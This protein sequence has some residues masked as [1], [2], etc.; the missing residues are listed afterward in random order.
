MKKV[1]VS[2]SGMAILLVVIAAGFL[3]ASPVLAG[4]CSPWSAKAVSVQGNVEA[5]RSGVTEWKSVRLDDTYCAGDTIRVQERSR[6]DILLAND[7]VLRLDQGTAVTISGAETGKTFLIDLLNG[8]AHFFSRFRRSLTVITPFVNATVEGTEFLVRVDSDRTFISIYEGHVSAL[9]ESGNLMIASGQSAVAEKG[10]APV[11]QVVARPRDAVQ[12]T[13]Y[14]PPVFPYHPSKYDAG[15]DWRARVSYL[16]SVG[17]VDEAGTELEQALKTSPGNSDALAVQSIIA[18]ARN[19]KEKAFGL[20]T[21]AVDAGPKSAS[22]RIALSYALQARFD[23]NGALESLKEAVRLEPENALAWARLSE[24]WL[25]FGEQNEAMKA[26]ERAVAIDPNLARTQTVLGFARLSEMKTKEAKESFEKAIQ[27]DQADPLPRL[28]LGLAMIREGKLVEGRSEI[29]IAE[30]LDPQNS[31]MRSYLGK[32][33]YDEKRDEKASEQF[34]KAKEFDPKDP[35]PYFYDAIRKQSENRPVEAL[36]D[37]QKSMELND[38]RAVYRSKLLLDSDLAARSASLSGIYSDLGFQQL[39]FGEAAKSVNIDP[40]NYSA[41]RFL[42]DSYSVLPRHEIARVS[43][44][45]QSQLLQPISVAPV[46]PAAAESSLF[47][48]EGAGPSNPSFN[49]FNPLFNRNRI[50]F[51]ASGIAGGNSTFGDEVVASGVYKNFALSAGQFHYETKGFR[52]NNDQKQNIYDVFAQYSL[53]ERTSVQAE[54]RYKDSEAGALELFFDPNYFNPDERDKEHNRSIRLGLHHSFESNS[55]LIVSGIYRNAHFENKNFFG[56]G[57]DLDHK[58]SGYT[59]EV[60]HLFRSAVISIISGAGHFQER[61]ETSLFGK[62]ATIHPR[63]TNIYVYA[64]VNYPQNITWTVGGSGNFLKGVVGDIPIERS[65]FS[66]KFGVAWSPFSGTTLRAAAFRTVTR[67]LLTDQTIELTQVAGFNQFFDDSEGTRSWRYGIGGDQ[68]FLPQ[69]YGGVEFSKRDLDVFGALPDFE[70]GAMSLI[71]RRWEEKLGRAYLN[72]TPHPWLALRSEYQYE[73]FKRPDDFAADNITRLN[74]HRVL[75]G[76]GVF[77]PSGLF[78]KF[79]PTYI[80]QDGKF[81]QVMGPFETEIVS[82]ESRFWVFDASVGYRLPKRLG[83]FTIEA[84]NLF[85]KTFQFQD[86]DPRDPRMQPKRLILARL[87]LAF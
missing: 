26:A 28:G 29:E 51:Q 49:E 80:S 81:V 12:W 10:K 69:L 44:L 5:K 87:T 43:E 38:N 27:M 3:M 71:E 33:Y 30:T 70:T 85:N 16:L 19:D 62:S 32:A 18:L 8:A 61:A 48:L 39:A 37:L 60:Q 25:S 57:I 78:A 35:T 20:A 11:L 77:H 40:A 56:P 59:G 24:L 82:K 58:R 79:R 36:Q 66:P 55:D 1:R 46:R 68:R 41:H 53:S 73:G 7:V 31:L 9:N 63:Q 14:Y 74:T 15:A 34:I 17:R 21:R 42:S 64:L 83:I 75:L 2:L 65:Q 45:L 86:T 72:W 54:F 52:A 67:G 6:A 22:A 47:I 23:L 4:T 76:V 13:L 84:K 50:A